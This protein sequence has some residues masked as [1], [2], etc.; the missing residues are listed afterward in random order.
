MPPAGSPVS[1]AAVERAVADAARRFSGLQV[2]ADTWQTQGSIERLQNAGVRI[3]PFNFTSGSV[4]KLSATLYS[5]ITSGT[6]RVYPDPGLEREVLDLRVVQKAGGWR[7]DHAAGGY[8]DRAM[9]LALAALHVPKPDSGRKSQII[10]GTTGRPVDEDPS[11]PRFN[12]PSQ[13]DP[14]YHIDYPG[15]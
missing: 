11:A 10:N 13:P 3:R 5:L 1:I 6:L 7:V 4:Q 15:V 9:A 12:D 2:Y 14:W 8:S